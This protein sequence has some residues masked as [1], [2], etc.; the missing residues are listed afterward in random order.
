M[1]YKKVI[2]L[3]KDLKNSNT[4]EIRLQEMEIQYKELLENRDEEI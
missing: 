1:E 3:N 4:L 2:K